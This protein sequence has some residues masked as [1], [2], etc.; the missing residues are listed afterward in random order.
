LG[1]DEQVKCKRPITILI[2]KKINWLSFCL[3]AAS[4]WI[5]L[6]LCSLRD[7]W[8]ERNNV[9]ETQKQTIERL[10]NQLSKMDTLHDDCFKI[11]EIR[12]NK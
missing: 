2:M 7:E 9:I 6:I 12:K 10:N 3:G 11:S 4:V 5:W 1:G 8:D